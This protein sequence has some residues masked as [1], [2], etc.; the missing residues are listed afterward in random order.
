MLAEAIGVA[1]IN[2]GF[3]VRGEAAPIRNVA[4]GLHEQGLLRERFVAV[5][6]RILAPP[7]RA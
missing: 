1:W 7:V 4:F 2:G 3:P 6:E 5:L